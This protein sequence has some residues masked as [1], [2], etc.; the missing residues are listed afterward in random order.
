MLLGITH[1]PVLIT[2]QAARHT[3][4]WLFMPV[5]WF[6]RW[7]PSLDSE[8]W[9]KSQQ[10]SGLGEGSLGT[11]SPSPAYPFLATVQPAMWPSLGP[12]TGKRIAGSILNKPEKQPSSALEPKAA[13]SHPQQLLFRGKVSYPRPEILLSLASHFPSRPAT[14]GAAPGLPATPGG[15]SVSWGLSLSWTLHP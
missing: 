11:A 15:W 10:H 8:N 5:C 7:A 9:S 13:G 14:T 1:L 6:G 4:D 2:Q 3:E 12:S